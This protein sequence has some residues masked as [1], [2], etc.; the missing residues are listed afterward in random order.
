M[1]FVSW[2]CKKS[3][4]LSVD[5][6]ENREFL[7]SVAGKKSRNSSVAEGKNYKL[8]CNSS[9]GR[10]IKLRSSSVGQEKTVKFSL[11]H[12][13]KNSK[14]CRSIIQS[15]FTCW[16]REKSLKYCKVCWSVAVKITKF[17]SQLGRKI[18]KVISPSSQKSRK[19]CEIFPLV[20]GK[21]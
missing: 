14:I 15:K 7:Q 5:R 18:A 11:S 4:N 6:G 10:K 13:K 20:R 1:K 9:I 16:L 17:T 21:L 8:S 2:L 12:K 3:W 19:C